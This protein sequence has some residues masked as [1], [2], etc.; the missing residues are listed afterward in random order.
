MYDFKTSTRVA[1]N[2]VEVPA[3]RVVI[4]E[5]I[6]ALSGQV[7][8]AQLNAAATIGGMAHTD[9]ACVCSASAQCC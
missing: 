3:S 4:I 8:C 7:R 6:Y 2:T 1:M 5:G 9:R